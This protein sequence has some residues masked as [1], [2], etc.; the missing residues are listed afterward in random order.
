ML[1]GIRENFLI[2]KSRTH[3]FNYLFDIIWENMRCN[4]NC[5]IFGFYMYCKKSKKGVFREYLQFLWISN[6]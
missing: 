3:E 2:S 1:V 4:E 6:G 5:N